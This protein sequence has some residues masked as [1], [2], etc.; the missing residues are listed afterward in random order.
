MHSC[1]TVAA[2]LCF[3]VYVVLVPIIAQKL[4][5][6]VIDGSLHGFG[7]Q[8][9]AGKVC[10]LIQKKWNPMDRILSALA[11][12]WMSGEFVCMLSYYSLNLVCGCLW[13]SLFG[14][15]ISNL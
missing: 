12:S 11:T 7:F 14:C 2:Q 8:L 4:E 15:G 13:G 10:C 6:P 3:I 9:E 1:F 5:Y